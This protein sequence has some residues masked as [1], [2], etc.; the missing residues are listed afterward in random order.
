MLANPLKKEYT[1]STPLS[2][3][4]T[5]SLAESRLRL[6]K[7]K[8]VS[9]LARLSPEDREFIL[10]SDVPEASGSRN[11]FLVYPDTDAS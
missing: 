10:S 4:A 1:S 2:G 5:L 3:E 9:A 7:Q 11:K 6:K 8:K